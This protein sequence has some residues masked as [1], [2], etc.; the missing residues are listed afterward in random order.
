V[1]GASGD[2]RFCGPILVVGD[3]TSAHAEPAGLKGGIAEER[4]FPYTIIG[5]VQ[6]KFNHNPLGNTIQ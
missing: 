6:P 1:F 4:A 3:D 5:W 2:L